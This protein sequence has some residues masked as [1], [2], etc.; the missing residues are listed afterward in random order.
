MFAVKRDPLLAAHEGES[1]AQLEQ[2]EL[3]LADQG[4]FQVGLAEPLVLTESGE[5]QDHGVLHQV[6]WSRDLVP[7]VGQRHDARLVTA[8]GQPLEEQ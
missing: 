4:L 6:G 2:E 7:F 5:L 3:E 1:L 8:E